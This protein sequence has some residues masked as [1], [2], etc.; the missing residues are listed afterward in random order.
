MER[1]TKKNFGERGFKRRFETSLTMTVLGYLIGAGKNQK[2]PNVVIRQSAAKI[3]IQRE[4]TIVGDS[5]PWE[6]DD[7]SFRD[8]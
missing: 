6:S 8:F 4:R 1:K 7:D 3:Q 2:N 5:K